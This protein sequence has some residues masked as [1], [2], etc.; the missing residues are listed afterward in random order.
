MRTGIIVTALARR[1]F[2]FIQDDATGEEF[3]AH[4][5]DFPDHTLLPVGTPIEFDVADF[6]GRPKAIRIKPLAPK[7]ALDPENYQVRR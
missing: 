5:L 4:K 3:F 6:R 1:S 7:T 2:V